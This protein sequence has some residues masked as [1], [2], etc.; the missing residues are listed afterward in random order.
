MHAEPG[1]RFGALVRQLKVSRSVLSA[2]LDTLEREGWI[3]RN[4]G[5]GHPLRP[6]YLLTAEGRR[7]AA[8]AA[9]ADEQFAGFELRRWTLP[10]LLEIAN[11]KSR[12]GELSTALPNITPRA[13]SMSLDQLIKLGWAEKA[14][15]PSR[16]PRYAMTD[17]GAA[18][19][20][21]LH[22]TVTGGS[23]QP[24]SLEAL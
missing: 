3:A 17:D 19:I 23:A 4:P 9:I 7:A 11:G 22:L 14:A 15:Q 16:H 8:W 20:G 21:R 1:S 10:A 24:A 2:S 18:L 6:E 5:H 13:L 12:F